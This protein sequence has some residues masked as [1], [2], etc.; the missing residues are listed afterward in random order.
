MRQHIC[1]LIVMCIATI[2]LLTWFTLLL[3]I[4]SS[5][6]FGIS[7]APSEAAHLI[8]CWGVLLALLWA[9]RQ[10]RDLRIFKSNFLSV[11]LCYFIHSFCMCSK[12]YKI[13]FL[14]ICEHIYWWDR[15]CAWI[16]TH[17][18]FHYVVF[19]PLI[20]IILV[21]WVYIMLP[22]LLCVGNRMS[23]LVF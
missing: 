1:T 15:F 8:R 7:C 10:T 13:E 21:F 14:C 18:Q 17:N 20:V 19:F 11:F 4:L 6:L 12:A 9:W 3:L 23:T 2:V 22:T 5:V 16:W